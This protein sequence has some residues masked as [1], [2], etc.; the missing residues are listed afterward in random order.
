MNEATTGRIEKKFK[1]L[2]KEGRAAFIPFIMAADPTLD[3]SLEILKGL[4]AAGADI[5]EL[6]VLFSDP[7]ACLLYTS[8]AADE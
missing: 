2:K 3:V 5:I 8:D 1:F 6:G 7:M 4:P